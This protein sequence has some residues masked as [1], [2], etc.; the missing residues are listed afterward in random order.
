MGTFLGTDCLIFTFACLDLISDKLALLLQVA[1]RKLE[2]FSSVDLLVILDLKDF[3]SSA[4]FLPTSALLFL[5]QFWRFWT[6]LFRSFVLDRL[7]NKLLFVI[8]PLREFFIL[9]VALILFKAALLD[10]FREL[11][12]IAIIWVEFL[13]LFYRLNISRTSIAFGFF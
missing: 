2:I 6:F 3:N 8:D 11:D 1:C 13:T 12:D 5:V 4:E 10:A 7:L 9:L